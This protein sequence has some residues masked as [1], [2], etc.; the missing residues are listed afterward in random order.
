M[1]GLVALLL[2]G[3]ASAQ[4]PSQA[5]SHQTQPSD[6]KHVMRDVLLPNANIVFSSQLKVPNGDKGWQTVENAASGIKD[7]ANLILVSGRLR[8]NGQPVSTSGDG[9]SGPA[10]QHGPSDCRR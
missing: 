8:S 3:A 5:Q 2:A 1:R 6:L 7:A 9:R 4:A 10:W